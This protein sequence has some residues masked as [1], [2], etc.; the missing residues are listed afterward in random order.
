[1]SERLFS[2]YFRLLFSC[3]YLTF[4]AD[5]VVILDS[6]EVLAKLRYDYQ[7]AVGTTACEGDFM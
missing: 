7:M 4:P 3:L 1:M 2:S 5:Q 6:N